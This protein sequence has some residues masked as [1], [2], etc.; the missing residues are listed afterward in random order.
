MFSETFWKPRKKTD[1][2]CIYGWVRG[3]LSAEK[4]WMT[5]LGEEVLL[6]HCARH[7]HLRQHPVITVTVTNSN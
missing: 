3:T 4:E 6:H 1:G 7:P 5:A 2:C